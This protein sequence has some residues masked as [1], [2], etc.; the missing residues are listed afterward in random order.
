MND[1]TF[2]IYQLPDCD[3]NKP[4]LFESYQSLK[5]SG[6]SVDKRNYVCVYTGT[7]EHGVDPEDIYTWFHVT[8]SR[9]LLERM[10]YV[11]DVIVLRRDGEEKAYYVDIPGYVEVPWVGDEP[12]MKVNPNLKHRERYDRPVM[13]YAAIKM[14]T[15]S[16]IEKHKHQ[17]KKLIRVEPAEIVHYPHEH[18]V[19]TEFLCPVCME[20]YRVDDIRPKCCIR[21]GQKLDW[22]DQD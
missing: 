14:A 8:P 19:H 7:L 5:T 3:D 17:A 22:S 18:W 13:G 2:S 15:A 11:S 6:L 10:L 20:R 4:L 1:N 16:F 12:P 9:R 21:C